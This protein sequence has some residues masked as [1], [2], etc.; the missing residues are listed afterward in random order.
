MIRLR[1]MTAVDVPTL[2]RIH[3]AAT[4]SSYGAVLTWLAPILDD[5]ATPLDAADWTICAVE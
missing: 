4:R 1:P 5:P 2:Q 3:A